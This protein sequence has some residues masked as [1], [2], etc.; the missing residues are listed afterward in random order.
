MLQRRFLKIA[1]AR[2]AKL[3][4]VADGPNFNK[5]GDDKKCVATRAV[6]EKID[7]DCEVY[8]NY[9]DTNM[10]CRARVSSGLT[11]VFE[12]VE[13]TVI[14]E[15]DCLLHASFFPYCVELLDRYRDD[16]RIMAICGA[17]S[18]F[19]HQRSPYSYYFSIYK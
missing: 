7:W 15:D 8:R 16:H 1:A 4:I 2:P 11:W 12:R 17:N 3:F 6:V 9:A 14:L 5:S 19:G 13:E 10:G 18:Q